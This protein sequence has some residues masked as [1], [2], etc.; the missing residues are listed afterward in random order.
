MVVVG[1]AS[2][3]WTDDR[4]D[5]LAASLEPLVTQVAVLSELVQDLRDDTRLL[6]QDLTNETLALRQELAAAQR[7][8]VQLAWGLVAALVGAV[9]AV[10]ASLI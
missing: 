1:V 5:D 2:K 8:L 6:R 9:V 3:A 7:Q 4:L 10:L